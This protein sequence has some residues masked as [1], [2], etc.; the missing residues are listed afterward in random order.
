MEG[1]QGLHVPLLQLIRDAT[2]AQEL[3]Q[4]NHI[5]N[6]PSCPSSDLSH[7][8]SNISV[9]AINLHWPMQVVQKRQEI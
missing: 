7:G 3:P 4:G 8:S 2:R 6:S 5:A 1:G 9:T